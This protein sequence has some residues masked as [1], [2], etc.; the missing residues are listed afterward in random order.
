MEKRPLNDIIKE[1]KEDGFHDLPDHL[2]S[3][4]PKYCA[5]EVSCEIFNYTQKPRVL[6]ILVT[7][8]GK[9][10][11]TF[12]TEVDSNSKTQFEHKCDGKNTKISAMVK[13]DPVPTGDKIECVEVK[14]REDVNI[15]TPEG[16]WN[17]LPDNVMD[18]NV[19]ASEEEMNCIIKN[20]SDYLQR[21]QISTSYASERTIQHTEV[22]FVPPK[23]E[24]CFGTNESGKSPDIKA[25]RRQCI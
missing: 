13:D 14:I 10:L 12:K 8:L 5:D 2:L 7:E 6:L 25:Y 22:V 23:G 4:E 1:F 18:Y 24:Y 16:D 3:F 15:Q 19:N 17:L 20:N 9:P 11:Y 21:V